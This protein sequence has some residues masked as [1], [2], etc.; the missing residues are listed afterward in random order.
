MDGLLR[1]RPGGRG[2]FA[3]ALGLH[4]QQPILRS[5]QCGPANGSGHRFPSGTRR[6]RW[7]GWL[8]L[9]AVGSVGD[10]EGGFL[11][12][13]LNRTQDNHNNLTGPGGGLTLIE[14]VTTDVQ[15][16]TSATGRLGLA[17]A[18]NWLLY[19]KGGFAAGQIQTFGATQPAVPG[20]GWNSVRWHMGWTGGGGFEYRLFRNVTIGAEYNYYRLD[21]GDHVGPVQVTDTGPP[22]APANPV[23]HRVSA[24][25][26]TVMAR[27]NFYDFLYNSDPDAPPIIAKAYSPPAT[28]NF[29]AFAS[30]EVKYSGWNGTRGPNVFA[31]DPG[32]GYQIY[33]PTTIG[34]NYAVPSQVNIESGFKTGYV[35]SRNDTPGQGATYNGPVDSQVSFN[36]TFL[37]FDSVRP[38]AGLAMNLPTG[39]SY[40]PGNQRFT[41][42]DPDL[43]EIG[44]YGAGFNINPT[45]GFV[46]GLNRSTAVS[47]SAGYAWNGAFTKEGVDLSAGNGFGTFNLKRRIKPGDAFTA[48]AN[49][50]TSIGSATLLTSFAYMSDSR[51]TIDSVPV[52]RSGARYVSNAAFD[53]PI[54]E[55]W[56]LALN[57]SWS[58]QEKNAI[59]GSFGGLVTEPGSN[60]LV[61]GSVDPSYRYS[62]RLKLG[63]NYSVLWREAN[64]Y[65]PLNEMFLPAK[66]KQTVGVLAEYAISPSASI[67][68]HASHSWVHQDTG[69]LLATTLIPPCLP[70]N[71]LSRDS[72]QLR[73]LRGQ[74]NLTPSQ[75]LRSSTF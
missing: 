40:L 73:A 37:S 41:R 61:I 35:Y 18:P 11:S 65:D 20:F 75:P 60:N 52:S 50:T 36:T 1:R 62:E 3:I 10:L 57:G 24:D 26:Q 31:P 46:V 68:A 12:N 70:S 19:G 32:K 74:A 27:I 33:A 16:I 64:G 53:L 67:N 72:L 69:P 6:H 51:V 45:G 34:V 13:P 5:G 59:P 54:D 47:F 4:Q 14:T 9:C 23:A 48:N 71:I 15:S 17:I 63:A 8:Q 29:S 58:F 43:V 55:R 42:M 2:P 7:P 56:A 21:A 28:G 66:L 30:S 39:N 22:P 25:V 49:L 38:I 44:S